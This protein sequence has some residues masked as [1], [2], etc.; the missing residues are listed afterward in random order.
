[1]K[2][3]ISILICIVA[4]FLS[5]SCSPEKEQSSESLAK[6]KQQVETGTAEMIQEIDEAGYYKVP[7][8]ELKRDENYAATSDEFE[9]FGGLKPYKEHFLE[10]LEYTG[11]GRG[12]PEP[13][14]VETVKLGFIGP[15][16]STVSVSTGGRSEQEGLGKK[17]L[18]GA[19]L[20]IE[21]ANAK[22][23]YLDRNI[24]FELVIKNDNGLWGASGNEIVDMVY[25]DKVWAILGTIDGANS[26]I[27]IRVALKAEVLMMNSGNTDPTFVETNIPWVMRCMSDDRQ[28][29][30]LLV[31][32][33]YKKLRYKKVGVIR[34]SSRYG[35]FGVREVMD[36]SRRLARPVPIEMAYKRGIEDFSL[37]L[38]RL[39]RENVDAIVHWGEAEDGARILNQAREMGMEQPFFMCDRCL[40]D[41]FVEI[42]GDNAQGVVCAYPWDPTDTSPKLADFRAAFREKFNEEPETQAAH[43]YDGM[44]MLIWA[45]QVAGLNRAKIRDIL[46]YRTEPWPGVTGDIIFSAVLDD[47]GQVYLA[48]YKEDQWVFYSREDLAIPDEIISD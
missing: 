44:N 21:Q 43:G 3:R 23:G 1:M 15:I 32:Y 22:G 13:E 19:Q 26:H 40:S 42:A 47:I 35:R 36:G 17:M 28:Q 12:I 27:A 8:L 16:E 37:H 29:G 31:D 30:Y 41:E 5:L 18:Q 45:T 11:S 4:V 7:D 10:Q 20:A 14:Q 9:P 34:S 2:R 6:P 38:E 48:R 39:N 46:A 24:P 33:M 25:K